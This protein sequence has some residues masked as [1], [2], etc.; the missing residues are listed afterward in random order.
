MCINVWRQLPVLSS[1]VNC[2]IPVKPKKSVTRYVKIFF[3]KS[4]ESGWADDNG[5]G[6]PAGD[7]EAGGSDTLQ[8]QVQIVTEIP[9]SGMHIAHCI[10]HAVARI[11]FWT[12]W[13]NSYW[14]LR[15]VPSLVSYRQH[16]GWQVM[17][18]CTSVSDPEPDPDGSG[19]FCRS[20][21]G[22][23]KSGSGSVH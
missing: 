4:P 23:Y 16:T 15:S 1:A 2:T 11:N 22:F 9:F 18:H 10:V 3:N 5:P 8:H 12:D 13:L 19:F 21:S 14:Y 7:E 6:Q 17:V 20:G